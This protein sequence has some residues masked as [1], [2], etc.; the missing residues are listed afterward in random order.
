MKFAKKLSI[1]FISIISFMALTITCFVYISQLKTIKSEVKHRLEDQ[2]FHTM[3]KIDRF[4][5][6][7]Y[8]DIK[9]IASDPIISSRDSTQK[10]ITERLIEYRNMGKVYTSLSFFDLNRVRIADTNLM[11]LGIQ[12]EVVQWTKDT[13]DKGNLSIARDV[14][15]AEDLNIVV[16][17]FASPVKDKNGKPFGVVVARMPI[18]KLYDLTYRTA[19]I[20][21]EEES[22]EIDLVNRNGLLLYSNYNRKGI[23]IDN[24]S[25][26]ESVTRAIK[27][28]LIGSAIHI[29]E[30]FFTE[31]NYFV[32][33][34][35][36][37]YLDFKGN[38]WIFLLHI[39]IKEAYAPAFLLRNKIISIFCFIIALSV[40][41]I[42]YF[43]KKVTKP[44][45]KLRDATIRIGKG[46]RNIELDINSKDEIG[47]LA[48]S[49]IQ[50]N[51]DLEKT[52]VS[53]NE[54]IEEI[55]VRKQMED[56]LRES[57]ERYRAVF[58]QLADS[59]V[60]VD[61]DTGKIL[62]FNDR[63]H[64]NLGY[65][66]EEFKKLKIQDIDAME[67]NKDIMKLIEK[68]KNVGAYAFE[69]KHRTKSGKIRDMLINTRFFSIRGQNLISNIWHD[70]TDKKQIEK[71][72]R[73]LAK[74][75]SE[76]PNPV[77]RISKAGKILFANN[78]G[79]PL[80]N[81]WGSQ[82]GKT[83]SGH[84]RKFVLNV[85]SSTSSKNTEV[86][87][88]GR[89]LS[90]TFAP[91]VESGYVNIYGLDITERKKME[92]ALL[93][94]EK[95]RAMGV[96]TSGVAH[97]FNNIL[98]II[99]A[100]AQLMEEKN[101]DDKELT[102][103]LRTICRVAED[104]ANIVDRMYE[105]INVK[106]DASKFVKVDMRNLVKQVIDF[107]MPRWKNMAQ[108]KGITYDINKEGL[109]SVPPLFGNPSELREVLVNIINN[110]LDAM[111]AGGCISFGTWREDGTVYV[112]ISDTGKGMSE[113][114][115]RKL[116]DPFF[117]TKRPKGSGLGMSVTYGI[118]T[119]HD[120]KIDV[121][122]KVGKGSTFTLKLPMP[123]ETV[124][125]VV[126]PERNREIKVKN[127]NILVVDD[128]QDMCE[129]LS[130]FFIK[131][132]HKVKSV[133]SGTDGI[134]L[135][136]SEDFDLILCD[137]VMPNVTGRDVIKALDTL[138]KRPKV[139]LITGW[140]YEMEDV[141]KEDL[142]VDFVMR[143]PFKLSEIRREIN[144]I[145]SAG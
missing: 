33:V 24:L 100:N 84:W 23:M 85:L 102:E 138:D 45:I 49:F 118:I 7:R 18:D 19:G 76:N 125:P 143:K 119:R 4:L 39:P 67:S 72:I 9:I 134:S 69:T 111:P 94:S 116:F 14:R 58:E 137:L 123:L 145:L 87:Y 112:S 15:R 136:K 86:R 60:V 37:G 117:T 47:E 62:E 36:Q 80:L 114:V 63:A 21:E 96:M 35:E 26:W 61:G 73:D 106:K 27:G 141:E 41:A 93:Q 83:L 144:N 52:T 17:Y 101:G 105:F 115:K 46:D 40:L 59:L 12:H 77:L 30:P 54:L 97:E 128:E 70:I 51:N 98:G 131:E 1:L 13:F 91:V 68:I 2:A 107:T 132:G 66:R 50:M 20:H 121:E 124:H 108:A 29:D 10:Q 75:P 129:T 3:D 99:S 127:L 113:E 142:K 64:K 57:E 109:K 53:R 135:L 79:L 5:Y 71:E 28:E 38:G 31:E 82:I 110:A 44:L 88:N 74:F 126:K 92:E 8:T 22:V 89:I 16:V 43:A 120:G 130:N 32:F 133:N 48:N 78:A 42:L 140:R 95:M 56:V 11:H 55:K 104:G 25:N 6:E 34:R 122:S 65:T 90:L 103:A 81:F 139:G